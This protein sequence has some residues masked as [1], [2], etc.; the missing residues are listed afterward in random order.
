MSKS[1]N[2]NFRSTTGVIG[3]FPSPR[4][5]T[6]DLVVLKGSALFHESGVGAHY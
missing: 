3:R 1:P 4:R 5:A 2:T 6:D